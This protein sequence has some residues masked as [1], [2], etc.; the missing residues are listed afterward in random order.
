MPYG[1][2]EMDE[3]D[4][5]SSVLQAGRPGQEA[6][7]M[8]PEYIKAR[9]DKMQGAS[10]EEKSKP[11][12]SFK[13]DP[14]A[15]AFKPNV[16]AVAFKPGG[17][18]QAR[19]GMPAVPATNTYVPQMAAAA[20]YGQYGAPQ[21]ATYNPQA[22]MAAATYGQMYGQQPAGGK[23][24]G[25]PNPYAAQMAM[26][27]QANPYGVVPMAGYS[28]QQMMGMP[29]HTAASKP[30]VAPVGCANATAASTSARHSASKA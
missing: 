25:A 15:G 21:M 24:Y 8:D 13:L 22:V 14:T 2:E 12:S 4:K 19:G 28:P 23:G 1:S 26:M 5:H 27:P 7:A 17:V 29:P 10:K 18:P 20:A 3:E 11:K 30:R 16:N 6:N 9:L